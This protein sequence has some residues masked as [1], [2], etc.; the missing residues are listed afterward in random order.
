[1]E[2]HQIRY[3]L[4]LC[5]ELHFTRAAQRCAVAQSSLTRA[6]G[7]LETELGGALFH[8]ARADTRLTDLG[9]RVQPFLAQAYLHVLEASRQA[10]DF[11]HAAAA[12]DVATEAGLLETR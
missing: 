3:F 4:A 10:Q 9:V 12:P 11:S 7:L 6:I 1:M 8:R 5:E 2:L